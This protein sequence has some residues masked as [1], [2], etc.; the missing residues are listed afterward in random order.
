VTDRITGLFGRLPALIPAAL[1][2]IEHYF[3]G[4]LPAA[5]ATVAVPSVTAWG[6]GG[7]DEYGDCGVI[8]LGHGF[9]AAA[10]DTARA[11]TFPTDAQ[12]VS[13]YLAYTGGEDDGVVL[14]AYLAH[15]RANGFYGHTVGAYVPVS[16]TSLSHIRFATW[17]YDFCYTGCVVTAAMMSA[18]SAGQPWTLEEVQGTPVGGHCVPLVGYDATYLYCVTWGAIQP[19]AWS[20]WDVMASEA[21]AVMTGELVT[22]GDDGHG[23]NLAALQADLARL[24]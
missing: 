3:A 14:S 2:E 18:F 11:E 5:P 21:W 16:V 23:L 17:A 22:A 19:I 7:N 6:M 12:D 13:Y 24:N 15:V 9:M 4:S 10:A 8:G 1:H 20:A